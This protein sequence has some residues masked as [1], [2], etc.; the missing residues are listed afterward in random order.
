MYG[1]PFYG[2]ILPGMFHPPPVE[3]PPMGTREQAVQQA[4]Q[5]DAPQV[6]SIAGSES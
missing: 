2:G 3:G 4:V 5:Q 1:G 6:G